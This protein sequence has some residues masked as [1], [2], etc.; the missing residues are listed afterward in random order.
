ML[1]KGAEFANRVLRDMRD[2]QTC[3]VG[4][5]SSAEYD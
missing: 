1:E 5:G 2:K 4:A 3:D